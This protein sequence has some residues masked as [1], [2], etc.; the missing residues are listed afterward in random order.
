M[1]IQKRREKL[2][3][4]ISGILKKKVVL[5]SDTLGVSTSRLIEDALKV[6]MEKYGIRS[7]PAIEDISEQMAKL[8]EQSQKD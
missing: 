5:L 1:K 6:H 2:N 4:S 7:E 3:I 8:D